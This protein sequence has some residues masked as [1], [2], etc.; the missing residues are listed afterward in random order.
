[1]EQ[2][3]N[4]RYFAIEFCFW[5]CWRGHIT[6]QNSKNISKPQ[7]KHK[8]KLFYKFEEPIRQKKQKAAE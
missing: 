2:T 7:Q 6:F 3:L 4:V 5:C 1:M 8:K